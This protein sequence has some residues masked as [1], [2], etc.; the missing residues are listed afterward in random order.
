MIKLYYTTVKGVD[1]IN[2]RPDLSLG[3]Y[4]SSTVVPNS[5]VNNLFSDISIYGAIREQDEFIGVIAKNESANDIENVKFWFDFPENC[6][7]NI[8]IAAV[9][10]D[11]TGWMEHIEHPY[12][13]PYYS[14][15]Y[16]ANGE[17][18][19]V[20]LGNILAGE[21][22]GLWFKL[23]VIKSMV[24]LPYSDANLEATG[25]VK[26]SNEDV[27]FIF[28]WD[29]VP[30]YSLTITTVLDGTVTVEGEEYVLPVSVN[31]NTDLDLVATPAEGFE[32]VDWSGDLVSINDTET[33]TMDA[34]KTIIATFAEIVIP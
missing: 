17:E 20:D 31:V 22:I 10:L 18:N 27:N 3:G 24:E 7:K 26:E 2:I 29:I 4:R 1:E 34:N 13:T 9:D 14:D 33:I 12:Q 16:E 32:F 25:N 5:V 28:E 6:Q 30:K 21:T 15:F 19:A 8:K 11:S 23:S